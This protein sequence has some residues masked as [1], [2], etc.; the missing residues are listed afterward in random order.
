[1]KVINNLIFDD[2]LGW[3]SDKDSVIQ[4]SVHISANSKAKPFVLSQERV[5]GAVLSQLELDSWTQP[6]Q[7][8]TLPS[9]CNYDTNLILPRSHNI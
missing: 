1:M 3:G 7:G 9:W 5:M 4:G 6:F 2:N 8:G